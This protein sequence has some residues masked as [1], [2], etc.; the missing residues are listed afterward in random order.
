MAALKAFVEEIFIFYMQEMKLRDAC[1]EQVLSTEFLDRFVV[2]D[3]ES[4][5]VEKV[6]CCRGDVVESFR[7]IV[8]VK[9]ENNRQ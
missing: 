1:C 4:F 5:D 8:E 6:G 2:G 7:E 3:L 9:R